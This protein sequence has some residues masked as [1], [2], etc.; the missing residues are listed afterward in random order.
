MSTIGAKPEILSRFRLPLS[1][2]MASLCENECNCAF[3]GEIYDWC[4]VNCETVL[5]VL[6]AVRTQKP[7]YCA[8]NAEWYEPVQDE[9]AVFIL[10][11]RPASL[12]HFR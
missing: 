6:A 7:L 5:G 1:T 12:L 3:C 9:A 4:A 2:V 11:E 10:L 8:L